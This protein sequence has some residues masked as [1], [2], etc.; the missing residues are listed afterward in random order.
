MSKFTSRAKQAYKII[1]TVPLISSKVV[2]VAFGERAEKA[3]FT[4]C[5]IIDWFTPGPCLSVS[6]L[7]VAAPVALIKFGFKL[8]NRKNK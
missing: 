5:S 3:A 4:A 1:N 8:K 7:V 6:C 2:G